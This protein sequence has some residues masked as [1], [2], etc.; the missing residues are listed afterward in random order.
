LIKHQAVATLWF[1]VW[2]QVA[3]LAPHESKRQTAVDE[4]FMSDCGLESVFDRITSLAAAHLNVPISTFSIIDR[5]RQFFASVHG[6]DIRETP[7]DIAF[8]AHTIL[9]EDINVVSDARC[10]PIF[11]DHPMVIGEPGI[12]FYAGAPVHAPNGQI[13]GTLTAVDTRPRDFTAG[14]GQAL[15]SLRDVVESLIQLLSLSV[16]DH[17]T[18]LYNRRHFDELIAREWFRACRLN[19]PIALLTID[20][21]QFK[22]YNDGNSHQ[23]GDRCLSKIANVLNTLSK[24]SGDMPFRIGGEEFA[25]LLTASSGR[26]QALDFA[27]RI[28]ETIHSLSIPHEHSPCGIVTVSIGLASAEPQPWD[29]GAM[30][31]F[32]LLSDEALY[33]AKDQGRDQVVTRFFDSSQQ[34]ASQ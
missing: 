4:F 29:G 22:S 23:A 9:R 20:I 24:R 6:L 33:A 1:E 5:D 18:R 32:I 21:D 27:N 8:C 2:M 17:L 10:H 3:A 19:L 7:R 12:V 13:I 11:H 30:N 31:D 14:M 28:R 16:L 25:V 34:L 15:L 26:K